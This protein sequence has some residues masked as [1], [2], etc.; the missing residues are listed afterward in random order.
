MLS[1]NTSLS[2]DVSINFGSISF[3]S[4]QC[5]DIAAGAKGV[6]HRCMTNSH[7][8][9]CGP[10]WC[11]KHSMARHRVAKDGAVKVYAR[12]FSFW[13]ASNIFPTITSFN[14]EMKLLQLT[15]WTCMTMPASHTVPRT[16]HSFEKAEKA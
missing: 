15:I 16:F 14:P 10:N 5:K 11:D 9:S 7:A 13:G 12:W 3:G 2:I 1:V 4:L 6:L 8:S